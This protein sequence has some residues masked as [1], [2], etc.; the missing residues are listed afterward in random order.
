MNREAKIAYDMPIGNNG[1][2]SS[3]WQQEENDIADEV[4]RMY[5]GISSCST[6]VLFGL[7]SGVLVQESRQEV[8]IKGPSAV[9][10]IHKAP[11]EAIHKT[12][13]A[14]RGI[15]KEVNST[16][17]GVGN[18]EQNKCLAPV[19]GSQHHNTTNANADVLERRIIDQEAVIIH[20]S[21]LTK[22]Q[23]WVNNSFRNLETAKHEVQCGI[24]ARASIT[25][26]KADDTTPI[27]N[28]ITDTKYQQIEPRDINDE[29]VDKASTNRLHEINSN[30]APKTTHAKS[31]KVSESLPIFRNKEKAVF[32][33]EQSTRTKDQVD[34]TSK[35]VKHQ[36]SSMSDFHSTDNVKN[37]M[38]TTW[39]DH[40]GQQNRSSVAEE[41]SETTLGELS[42]N[43]LQYEDIE[44]ILT[45]VS[46]MDEKRIEKLK[47]T[48]FYKQ[49][50]LK[51]VRKQIANGKQL[52]TAEEY[53]G[54]ESEDSTDN[55]IAAHSLALR[56]KEKQVSELR[57]SKKYEASK[58]TRLTSTHNQS[59]TAD[60]SRVSLSESTINEDSYDTFNNS[61]TTENSFKDNC[62][63]IDEEKHKSSINPETIHNRSKVLLK[64]SIVRNFSNRFKP[65]VY[66]SLT[67]LQGLARL[68]KAGE[69]FT[70]R[71]YLVNDDTSM[72]ETHP[73]ECSNDIFVDDMFSVQGFS[74]KDILNDSLLIETIPVGGN[75]AWTRVSIELNGLKYKATL[76][77]TVAM[78][79]S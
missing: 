76:L 70:V 56:A 27:K 68:F 12:V 22:V 10:N 55:K 77:S 13:H 69:L 60:R 75:E 37:L 79:M 14:T 5:S 9:Q 78:E 29:P 35:V 30:F 17:A 38:L 36:L 33:S 25:G 23:D 49:M 8:D 41:E 59:L 20:E 7:Q 2:I 48:D 15:S 53:D 16:K 61:L 63:K 39:V 11:F 3:V 18:I 45:S 64:Y 52:P 66:V 26:K 72:Q 31:E 19:T 28:D 47:A 74:T 50:L 32:C 1:I 21:T 34:N 58:A 43:D 57:V 54:M 24:T 46:R 62:S 67:H 73:I 40:V 44:S 65:L 42:A 51:K 6:P 4:K 71:M